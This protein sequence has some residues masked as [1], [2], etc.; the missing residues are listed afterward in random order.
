MFSSLSPDPEFGFGPRRDGKKRWAKLKGNL[1]PAVA[2]RDLAIQPRDN[3]LVLATHGRGI[4]IIDDITPLR[5]L[6]PDLLKQDVAF[7]SARPVQQR[8][9]G[10]GGGG[11]GGAGFFGDYSSYPARIKY[12]HPERPLFWKKK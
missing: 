12:Y 10:S 9:E 6:T 3:D 5:A 11:N 1:S 7:V 2:V 4:W 8:I